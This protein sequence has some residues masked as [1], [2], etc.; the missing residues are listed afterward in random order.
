LIQ[1]LIL[2][3]RAFGGLVSAFFTG[4]RNIWKNNPYLVSFAAALLVIPLVVFFIVNPV[5]KHG[6]LDSLLRQAQNAK[7]KGDIATAR[8]LTNKIKNI[9]PT[10]STAAVAAAAGVSAPSGN[11]T[12]GTSPG[13]TPSTPATP[14]EKPVY[15]GD[16]AGAFPKTLT[17]YTMV[18]DTPG[19]LTASRLYTTDKSLH[20]KV[21]FLTIQLT[22]IGTTPAQSAVPN[23]VKTYY[24]ASAKDVT[25]NGQPGYFGTDAKSIAVLAYPSGAILIELEMSV[26]G[27]S[28]ADL[29]SELIELSKSVP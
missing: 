8:K 2:P 10:F 9:D 23:S 7:A 15:S 16:L 6:Q 24:A 26:I 20:P 19:Q 13:T 12:G 11:Q 17:G 1:A 29:Y 4:L 25:V 3:E 5:I 18:K 28:P 21:D 14:G 22:S 27:G